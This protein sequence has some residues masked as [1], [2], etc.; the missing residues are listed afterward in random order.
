MVGDLLGDRKGRT[1]K[2]GGKAAGLGGE[3]NFN[4]AGKGEKPQVSE[5]ERMGFVL[6]GSGSG[7]AA[8]TAKNTTTLVALARQTLGVLTGRHGGGGELNALPV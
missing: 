8:T 2:A 6:S 5:L 3:E 1:K 4:L 7:P